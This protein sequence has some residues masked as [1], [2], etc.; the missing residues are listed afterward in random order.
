MRDRRAASRLETTH[1][2]QGRADRRQTR[3]WWL[4]QSEATSS[5]NSKTLSLRGYILATTGRTDQAE[6]VLRT[7]E[8]ISQQ[9]YVPPYALALVHA[10][11]GRADRAVDWL[12]HAYDVR[13]VH[14][15]WLPTDPKWDPLRKE[16]AFQRL[17]NRCGFAASPSPR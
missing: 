14:L 10:G 1:H 9:R 7:L 11:L 2:G 6:Q 15:V 13:D 3:D 16:S 4:V 12:R 5:G 17:I 8:S